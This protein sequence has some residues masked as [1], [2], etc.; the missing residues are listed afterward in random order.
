MPSFDVVSKV[1]W[2]EIDNAL[3]QATRELTQ[4]FDFKDTNT[5]IVLKDEAFQ[6]E[7]ADEHKLAAAVE[8]LEGKLAKRKVPLGA[9]DRGAIESASAGRARQT[10]KVR[11]G[12]EQ[13]TARAVVKAIKDAKLKVQAAIQ[14]DVV[15]V[16]GKKR[17]DLQEVIAMLRE[18]KFEQPLQ[19]ENF[20]D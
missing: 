15:R 13:E 18:R 16:S 7:S 17:D 3:N 19:Y 8:V 20:R 9:L 12:V 5:S 1:D 10:I 2:H 14:A 11:S 4:R 6:I